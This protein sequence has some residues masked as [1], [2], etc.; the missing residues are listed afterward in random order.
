VEYDIEGEWLGGLKERERMYVDGILYRVPANAVI[1]ELPDPMK[2]GIYQVGNLIYRKTLVGT[3]EYF[4]HGAWEMS[5]GQRDEQYPNA[6]LIEEVAQRT[7]GHD[8]E[9]CDAL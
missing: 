6:V 4:S 7:C 1:T 2:P 9:G 5:D 8:C 3:W